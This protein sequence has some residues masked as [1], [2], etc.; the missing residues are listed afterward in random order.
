MVKEWNAIVLVGNPE[1]IRRRV[2][3]YGVLA[4]N[5]QEA[6]EAITIYFHDHIN[7]PIEIEKIGEAQ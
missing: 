4:Q 3:V 5:E 2:K 7:E 6:K 1:R